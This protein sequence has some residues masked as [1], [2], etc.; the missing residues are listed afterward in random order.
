MILLLWPLAQQP[1][2]VHEPLHTF[3]IDGIASV[4]K[5]L[6]DS[7]DAISAL[8]LCENIFN[9][10][11]KVFVPLCYYIYLFDFKVVSGSGNSYC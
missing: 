6:I 10:I 3:M 1:S 7:P 5:F 11:Q 4:N 8:I 9:F 2:F